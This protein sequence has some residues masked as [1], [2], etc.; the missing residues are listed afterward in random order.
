M[1]KWL[2]R[3]LT[4]VFKGIIYTVL[5]GIVGLG[6]GFLLG[7]PLLKGAYV[8]IL[9]AGAFVMLVAIL[10][11]IGTP[12]NRLQYILKGRLIDGRIEQLDR[13][14]TRRDFSSGGVSPAIIAVV[15]I[16]MGFLVEALMH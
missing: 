6:V 1:G 8:L 2:E 10:L 9:G 4:D 7:W 11:L 5:F 13:D 3:I 16:I 12:R 15:M 14:E